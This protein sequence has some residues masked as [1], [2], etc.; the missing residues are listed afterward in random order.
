MKVKIPA[1]FILA[2]F[3]PIVTF[4]QGGPSVP[5]GR[6]FTVDNIVD[7]AGSVANFLYTIG[8]VFIAIMLI[9]SGIVYVT[10][11][12]DTTKITSAKGIFKA[13]LIG[14]L[15]IFGTS[16]IL[17]TLNAVATRGPDFFKF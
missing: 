15:I 5:T 16:T 4:A 8:V 10:A 11:G 14:G 3:I 12:S 9:W 6:P 7:I 17:A 13:A 2:G 1:A